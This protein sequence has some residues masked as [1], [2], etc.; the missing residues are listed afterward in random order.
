MRRSFEK[1]E[2][3]GLSLGH[4]F[5]NPIL[6]GVDFQWPVEKDI[7]IFGSAN[8]GK[9][10]VFRLLSGLM[11]PNRG[12][13]LI[14]D[15][16][17]EEM[18]FEEF[19]PYRL[20]IGFSF[21]LGGLLSNKSLLENLALPL[22]YHNFCSFNDAQK[23]VLELFAKFDLESVANLRPSQVSGSQRKLACVLRA[24]VH[25]PEWL[26]LDDPLTGLGPEWSAQLLQVIGD[27]KGSGQIKQVW[28]AGDEHLAKEFNI[29][30]QVFISESRLI[31]RNSFVDQK[32][33]GAA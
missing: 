16:K 29:E 7:L 14:N 5:E 4:S 31:F 8:T 3:Q 13:Y 1:I 32:E 10:S 30:T 22:V 6:D 19:L 33:V 27:L 21:D 20:N 17:V 24:L 28:L 2:F 9:S 18:S 23:N 12:S 15:Q 25:K 11:M 26:L